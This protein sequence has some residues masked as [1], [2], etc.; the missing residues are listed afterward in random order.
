MVVPMR[1]K[2]DDPHAVLQGLMR[3]DFSVFLRKAYSWIS[4]NDMM[5]WNWHL[6]AITHALDEVRTGNCRR[7][8]I[9]LPPRN[10]KSI[11]TSVAWVAW[12][13][14]W[15]P[16]HRFV[17]VSYSNELSLAL[18]RP[19][20]DIMESP[21]YRE[22]FPKTV[23][24]RTAWHDIETTMGGGRLAT[25]IT[26]TLTGRGGDTIILDDLIKPQEADSETIRASVN[27]WYQSTL[28]T[29]L[30]D[31]RTGA[32]VCVMQRLH[33][34]DVAGL[35]IESG[36][37]D[38]LSLPAIA[39]QDMLVPLPGGRVHLFKAGEAL[40]PAR[41]DL[42]VLEDQ[43][44]LMGSDRFS[45]QYLQNPVPA[46]GNLIKAA[47]LKVYDPATVRQGGG[48]IVMSVDPA[49]KANPNCDFSAIVIA[50]V[51]GKYVYVLEVVRERLEFPNLRARIVA[52]ADEYRP[53]ALL[54]E[55]K[56]SGEGLISEF[57]TP[58]YPTVPAPIARKATTDKVSRVDGITG[59]I[60]AGQLLLP[61]NAPWSSEYKAELLAFPSGK[62]DDQVDATVHLLDWVRERQSYITPLN[63]G[64]ELVDDAYVAAHYDP[65]EDP[66]SGLYD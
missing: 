33:E 40:H 60:E 19:C 66:W 14:G 15:D 52:L 12:M 22:L 1:R 23:L 57:R 9:T 50:L 8:L 17:C 37:Y 56:A 42:M 26:G 6:D 2:M 3:A 18:A 65:N 29:R 46:S 44:A 41:E 48:K 49:N 7:R 59:M 38:V 34:Y 35:M 28:T 11:A 58:D 39:D 16:R 27:A 36:R 64:P 63:A 31:K 32:I 45:A 54:I 55:D 51:Q 20:L 43:R 53:D 30:N 24:R 13:L 25:S 47:W 5:S 61:P 21:W 10:G 4:G 62:Y